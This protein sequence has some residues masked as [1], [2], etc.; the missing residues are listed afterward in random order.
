MRAGIIPEVTVAGQQGSSFPRECELGAAE[1]GPCS[2]RQGWNSTRWEAKASREERKGKAVGMGETS[3]PPWQG[4]RN[5]REL[6]NP[7]SGSGNSSLDG[8][9]EA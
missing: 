7:G 3:P 2:P 6:L 4:R 1:S 8:W 5:S 9:E